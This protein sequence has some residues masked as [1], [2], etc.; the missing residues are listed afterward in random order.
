MAINS[1]M[2]IGRQGM[3]AQRQAMQV[4]TGNIANANTPGYTRRRAHFENHA[5][6]M[7]G[8]QVI[9]GGVEMAH[10]VRVHDPFIQNQIL[11]ESRVFGAAR[12][13]SEKLQHI[14]R[15][16]ANDAFRAGDLINNFFNSVR[17]LS[18]NPDSAPLRENVARTG[19]QTAAGFRQ[20]TEQLEQTKSD[21]DRK[22]EIQVGE[23]NGLLHQ[24]GHLN[25]EIH[26]LAATS[27][28]P[29][30][31]YD[32]RE[33][34][35][36]ELSQKLG[37]EVFTDDQD[38]VNLAAGGLGILVH[39]S[40]VNE[41]TTVRTA[42]RGDKGE[43]SLD[44]ALKDP[45]GLR[46]V[47]H[48]I[49][50]GELGGMVHVRDKVINPTLN[51][52]DNVAFNFA[53]AVNEKHRD[54]VG[55]DNLSGR[56]LFE[57]PTMVSGAASRLSLSKDIKESGSRVAAAFASDSPGDNRAA[58][59]ISELQHQKVLPAAFNGV[60]AAPS[61]TFNDSMNALVGGIGIQVKHEDETFRHQEAILNQL[62]NYRQSVSGVSLE[63]EALELM[64]Y[65][66]VF[67]ASAKAMK[68]G[69]ELFQTI[70]SIKP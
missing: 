61:H 51:H 50:D 4:A 46:V 69:D 32:R 47:T 34:I 20:L 22:I 60:D 3:T 2:E 66:T 7:A 37:Y 67:Q 25:G 17:E 49:K 38:N 57:E 27:S 6:S 64:K 14:E 19:E 11:D 18:A 23:V 40:H 36:R 42:E 13:R 16:F 24:L 55:M 41:L 31:L 9:G 33:G 58:L 1:I 39:G 29:H 28:P 10:V 44:I 54:G 5:Q 65:Q 8:G 21:I 35:V 70:L 62:D 68:V 52:L 59:A 30:D 12:A 45:F 63:E 26:S 56:D 15:L 53:S 43:G 48:S